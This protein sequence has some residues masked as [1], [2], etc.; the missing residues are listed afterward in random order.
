MAAPQM[1]DAGGVQ[2]FTNKMCPF[3]QKAWVALEEKNVAFELV[4][5]GLYG[6]G[7]KPSWFLEMNPKGLVPVLK[8]GEKV[9]VESNDIL[10]YVDKY[11]GEAGSLQGGSPEV[12]AWMALLSKVQSEGK[13][14]MCGGGSSK[15]LP[16]TLAAFESK[17]GGTFLMGEDF[18]LADAAA[19][20]MFQRVMSEKA[21]FGLVQESHPRIFAWWAA[22][23]ARPSF[24]KTVVSNYWWWW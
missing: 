24:A 21:R 18:S 4:E 19:A 6:S 11:L 1:K 22:V 16:A 3:A 17:V 23:S 8:H 14:V 9:V 12:D 7:G 10:K 15:S 2:F 20:P 13:A 5:I